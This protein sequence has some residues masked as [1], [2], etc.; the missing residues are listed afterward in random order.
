MDKYI[1]THSCQSCQSCQSGLASFQN[2]VCEAAYQHCNDCKRE[3][4]NWD[5][6][7]RACDQLN[8]CHARSIRADVYNDPYNY[9]YPWSRRTLSETPL[10][11]QFCDNICGVNMCKAYKERNNNY[12][13]CKRCEQSGGQFR[14]QSGGQFRCWSPYH[15][16]C[17]ECGGTALTADSQRFKTCEEIW[18]CPN[19]NGAEFG[20]VAPIDPMYSD[21]IPCWDRGTE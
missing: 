18:G 12:Q 9:V 4:R 8:R 6:C 14:S 17:V 15:R 3:T 19:P 10:P 2:K 5:E 21:C 16:R 1:A 13:E 20:Y 11:T 7:W